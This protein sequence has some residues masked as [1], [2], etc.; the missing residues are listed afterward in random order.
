[1]LFKA[2]VVYVSNYTYTILHRSIVLTFI[3]LFDSHS[4]K[5]ISM[6][7]EARLDTLEDFDDEIV[8][9]AHHY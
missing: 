7:G 8:T 2:Y 3:I 4:N 9:T 5:A 6:R 1:M